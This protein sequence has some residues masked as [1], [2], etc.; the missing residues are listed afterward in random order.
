MSF[1]VEGGLML[2]D[3]VQGHEQPQCH[4]PKDVRDCHPIKWEAFSLVLR[5]CSASSLDEV[6]TFAQMNLTCLMLS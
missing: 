4:P 2:N 3:Q 6:L 1:V 5:Q